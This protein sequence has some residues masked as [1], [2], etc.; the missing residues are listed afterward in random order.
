MKKQNTKTRLI[1]AA[2]ESDADMLYATR[3]FA[4]DPFIFLEQNG[5]RTL[6]LSD[7]EIDRGRKQAEADEFLP[8]STF[9]KEVQGN[10]TKTP[11]YEK[12]L[13]HFLT[14]KKVR[15]AAVPANFPLGYARE[16]ESKKI[17]LQPSNGLFWPA[18]EAKSEPE[19]RLM[20][21][22]L[23]ITEAGMARGIA[24]LKRSKP[25]KGQKLEWSG[26]VLTS[27]LLRAEIDTA[28]LRAGGLPANTIV[29]GGD[30]ACDPH[31]RGHGPLQ[32]NS[33]IILDIFPRSAAS[34]YYGDLTR[35]VVRGRA[36][37]AQRKLWETVNAGQALALKK[38]KPGVDGLK[39]HKEVQ[40]FFTDQGYPTELRDGR[41]TGFFHGTGHGLGL[42]IHEHPRFQKTVFKAGQVLTVE[43]GLYYPGLGG[44]RTE[45]VVAL[46]KRGIRMLSRFGNRLDI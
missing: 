40:Q 15:S 16:L 33:L 44:V 34:G 27:E 10:S 30:Q 38:M 6:V 39:L 13:A 18:R 28:V 11:P 32:A 42:E 45:D 17:R 4:P 31:E 20:R 26:K 35:T 46:T 7:L 19:L 21:K 9:E 1:V 23:E 29:A 2:S 25:G 36:S 5:K 43:P 14:K 41:Q 8:Y 24:V 22:A 12:V 37:D 3:F